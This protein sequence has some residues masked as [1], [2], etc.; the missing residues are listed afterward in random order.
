MVMVD[1]KL[2]R[3]FL[4]HDRNGVALLYVKMKNVMYGLFKSALFLYQKLVEAIE[5]YGFNIYPYYPCVENNM[6]NGKKI[7]V[8]WHLDFFK[9]YH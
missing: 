3:K 6:I 9:V 8:T 1:P 2:Y 4:T 7:T 5:A